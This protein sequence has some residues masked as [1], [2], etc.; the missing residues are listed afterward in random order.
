MPDFDFRKLRG[1]ITEKCDNVRGLAAKS[2]I[3]AGKLYPSLQGRR[4]FRT[5]EIERLMAPD[6]LDIPKELLDE[7]F[8]TLKVR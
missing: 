3:P 8:F 1:R 7:Y 2:G 5:N 4:A 6:C